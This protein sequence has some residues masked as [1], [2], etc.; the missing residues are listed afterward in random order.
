MLF[1][2]NS[3]GFSLIEILLTL[4]IIALILPVTLQLLWRLPIKLTHRLETKQLYLNLGSERLIST[5][6]DQDFVIT[7][8]KLSSSFLINGRS[9]KL[10]YKPYFNTKYSN[11]ILHTQSP[12]KVS[13]SVGLG[14]LNLK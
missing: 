3:A 14:T 12:F 2:R 10:G 9:Q 1:F 13:L 6:L 8:D 7:P 4:M 11:T 5:Y